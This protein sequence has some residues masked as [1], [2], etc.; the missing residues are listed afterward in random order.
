MLRLQPMSQS[1]TGDPTDAEGAALKQLLLAVKGTGTFDAAEELKKIRNEIMNQEA[2]DPKAA[3]ASGRSAATIT[4]QWRLRNS[5]HVVSQL[6]SGR[7]PTHAASEHWKSFRERLGG[8]DWPTPPGSADSPN[9]S[10]R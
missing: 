3:T 9:P 10:S 4:S 6:R 2:A 1:P 5:F 7:V 8:P